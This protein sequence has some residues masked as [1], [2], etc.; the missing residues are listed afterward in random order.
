MSEPIHAYGAP[1]GGTVA[2]DI[3]KRI[4]LWLGDL[5]LFAVDTGITIGMGHPWTPHKNPIIALII[6]TAVRRWYVEV[7]PSRDAEAAPETP[8]DWL[9]AY[10]ERMVA[11][12]DAAPPEARHA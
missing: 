1:L 8:P 11:L 6:E 4:D 3:Q 5:I 7:D 9:R 2:E 10:A 12:G